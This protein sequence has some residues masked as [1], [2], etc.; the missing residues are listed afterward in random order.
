M[1]YLFVQ[2]TL[3]A[4]QIQW[5]EFLSECDFDINHIKGKDNNV[6]DEINRRV[7]EMHVIAISMY[8]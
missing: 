8:K 5:L 1:K 6:V 2:Q 4:R 3:N 7:H